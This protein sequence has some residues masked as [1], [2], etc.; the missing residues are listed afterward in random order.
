MGQLCSKRK[1]KLSDHAAATFDLPAME[2]L[3]A[4][5]YAG[6]Y[7]QIL[8]SHKL[9]FPRERVFEF[10]K[11]AAKEE[12]VNL[13]LCHV[14]VFESELKELLLESDLKKIHFPIF[15][16]YFSEIQLF[17]HFLFRQSLSRPQLLGWYLQQTCFVSE[18][19]TAVGLANARGLLAI[20]ARLLLGKK[21]KLPAELSTDLYLPHLLSSY[22]ESVTLL[23]FLNICMCVAKDTGNEFSRVLDSSGD[24]FVSLALECGV[25]YIS[26]F[27]L[28]R[29][30]FDDNMSHLIESIALEYPLLPLSLLREVSQQSIPDLVY[31]HF[32]SRL[33]VPALKRCDVQ[34]REQ[35]WLQALKLS[36]LFPVR[37][38]REEFVLMVCEECDLSGDNVLNELKKHEILLGDK[39]QALYTIYTF[40]NFKCVS[41]RLLTSCAASPD[42]R[43]SVF[44]LILVSGL[45]RSKPD[46]WWAELEQNIHAV[47]S[48]LS[49]PF[50]SACTTVLA[51][52]L[53]IVVASTSVDPSMGAVLLKF[54]NKVQESDES[55]A[56]SIVRNTLFCSDCFSTD[57]GPLVKLLLEI[58]IPEKLLSQE[59]RILDI[60]Q[61]VFSLLTSV[62]LS[63][64]SKGSSKNLISIIQA[65]LSDK[66][67][68]RRAELLA[69]SLHSA[70]FVALSNFLYIEELAMKNKG[71]IFT[72]IFN[73]NLFAYLETEKVHRL[74]QLLGIPQSANP[75]WT[76][77][78]HFACVA[79][80]SVKEQDASVSILHRL[81]LE[82][83]YT[84]SWRLVLAHKNQFGMCAPE[85]MTAAFALCPDEQLR[86]MLA[87]VQGPPPPPATRTAVKPQWN[88][89]R[90]FPN[91]SDS[92]AVEMFV[93]CLGENGEPS[94]SFEC[95]EILANM[96]HIRGEDTSLDFAVHLHK[97]SSIGC[98]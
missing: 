50:L 73:F 53:R 13:F 71:Q 6:K 2:I 5:D 34:R 65:S 72:H 10:L 95:S 37:E 81:C 54:L 23:L 14:D 40:F 26:D 44:R 39:I 83:K 75:L 20:A 98:F 45:K 87:V 67:R 82:Y 19:M 92:E 60:S 21:P 94:L 8:S 30:K 86:T 52:L 9:D 64:Q 69:A 89:L 25:H 97:L 59:R 51:E 46:T 93:S 42:R 61:Q 66:D 7:L 32:S 43:E 88:V 33:K 84:E 11:T 74:C 79:Y 41:L 24:N 55:L 47:A 56:K 63:P 96:T 80:I 49:V 16:D 28:M 1:R 91:L 18:G 62:S 36:E 35:V 12:I 90:E 76:R 48:H 57:V 78:L 27:G 3:E 29:M 85:V 77:I 58:G 15:F 4:P 31:L 17:P 22:S 70:D 68:R 38:E